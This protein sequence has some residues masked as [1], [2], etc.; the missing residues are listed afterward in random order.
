MNTN[1]SQVISSDQSVQEVTSI[2]SL[3]SIGVKLMSSTMQERLKNLRQ[4]HIKV[5]DLLE[6][7]H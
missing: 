7:F 4:Q 6:T 3:Q 5:R 1:Q 2:A